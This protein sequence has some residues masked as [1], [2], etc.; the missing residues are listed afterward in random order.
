[1]TTQEMERRRAFLERRQGGIGGSDIPKIIGVSQYG[2]ALDVYYDKTRPIRDEDVEEDTIHQKRGHVLEPMALA[3]Y[4][5]KTKR[6]G[7]AWPGDYVQHPD[8]PACI[9]TPD[10]ETFRDA[11]REEGFR[12]PGVVEVKS[13]VSSIFRR[14]YEEGLRDSEIVQLQF[15]CAVARREWGT[16]VYYTLEEKSGPLIHV[17]LVADP[18]LGAFLLEAAQRFWD[19]HVVPRIPPDP[20]EWQLMAAT[21]AP[22]LVEVTGETELLDDGELFDRK[23]LSMLDLHDTA[24]DAEERRK[25][26]GKEVLDRLVELGLKKAR[27]PKVA[28]LT[29]V[30]KKG[31]V[32]FNKERLRN[33]MP[34]DRD[35]VERWLREHGPSESVPMTAYDV[36][37]MLF[38]CTLDLE[39]FEKVG[40]PTRHLLA[41]RPKE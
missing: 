7:R 8:F 28:R 38:D 26:I 16:L 35:K 33:A 20:D 11:E 31:R 32:S 24:K 39:Q 40:A 30:T 41:K 3:E 4:W 6:K 23:L 37:R 18:R 13:P 34:L 25:A 1:M 21:D 36:G 15:N 19:E 29:V 12:G 22:K 27:V 2:D 10:A 14:V 17:D 5:Y 9:V